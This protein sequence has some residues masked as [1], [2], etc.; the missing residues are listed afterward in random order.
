M[1]DF[2]RRPPQKDFATYGMAFCAMIAVFG[3][4]GVA[5]DYFGGGQEE[6]TRLSERPKR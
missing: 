1:I 4:G 5:R 3:L 6:S 2:G